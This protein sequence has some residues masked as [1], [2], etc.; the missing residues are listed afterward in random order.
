MLDIQYVTD[1]TGKILYVQMPIEVYK[2]LIAGTEELTR[3]ISMGLRVL[4][5]LKHIQSRKFVESMQ[6][7]TVRGQSKKSVN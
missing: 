5:N 7:H 3:L 4:T 2:G 6:Q 1:S